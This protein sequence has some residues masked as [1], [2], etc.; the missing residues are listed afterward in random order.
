MELQLVFSKIMFRTTYITQNECIV[1][2]EPTAK[3]T[4]HMLLLLLLLN[5]YNIQILNTP[6]PAASAASP[7][8][9]QDSLESGQLDHPQPQLSWLWALW[10]LHSVQHRNQT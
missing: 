6:M 3:T 4:E 1:A 7:S 9:L 2:T 5:N 8:A 10:P